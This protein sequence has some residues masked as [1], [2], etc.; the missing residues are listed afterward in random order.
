M[1]DNKNR[2]LIID[3]D[4]QVIRQYQ[5]CFSQYQCEIEI[6]RSITEAVEKIR[7]IFF[8]CVIMDVDLPDMKGY[9]AIPILKALEPKIQIIMTAA[10]NTIE[11]E[12]HIRKQDVSYY[13][14]KSFDID[15]L[16]LAVESVF[17]KGTNRCC[18]NFKCV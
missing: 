2:I 16:H 9:E 10:E 18:S 6:C 15:E 7:N 17:R 8:P 3:P 14:I 13:Y 1:T 11:L 12:T 5:T 4:T